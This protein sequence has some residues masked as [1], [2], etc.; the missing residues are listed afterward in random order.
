MTCSPDKCPHRALMEK[1]RAACLHCAHIDNPGNRSGTIS[2]EK[3][4]ERVI[5]KEAA[6]IDRSPRGQVTNLPPEVEEKAKEFFMSWANLN[7]IDALLCLHVVNGGTCNDFKYYLM[8]VAEHIEKQHLD[9]DK[10]NYRS[11]AHAK[12]ENIIKRIPIMNLVK[13]WSE[14]HEGGG[15]IAKE[16]KKLSMPLFDNAGVEV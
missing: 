6:Y 15:S 7:T 1:A 2:A 5:H 13:T 14:G 4:G 9:R 12:F 3:A 10:D 8:K 11:T 16:I